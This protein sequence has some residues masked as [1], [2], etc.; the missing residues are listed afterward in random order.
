MCVK[1]G[2]DPMCNFFFLDFGFFTSNLANKQILKTIP[3]RCRRSDQKTVYHFF[4]CASEDVVCKV[5]CRLVKKCGRSREKP[6]LRF[7]RFCEKKL[8]TQMGVAYSKSCSRLQ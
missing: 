8:L 3:F 1:F 4:A 7:S 5:W 6:V 2:F